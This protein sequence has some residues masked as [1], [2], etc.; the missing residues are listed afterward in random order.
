MTLTTDV[1]GCMATVACNVAGRP[2]PHTGVVLGQVASGRVR[3]T[4]KLPR[5][6]RVTV[7]TE[8]RNVRLHRDAFGALHRT[9]SLA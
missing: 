6:P 1:R 7:I 8:P 5:G 4:V 3:L 9:R 2:G